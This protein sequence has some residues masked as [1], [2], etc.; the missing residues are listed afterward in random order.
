MGSNKFRAGEG[1]NRPRAGEGIARPRF[2]EDDVA[3]SATR[4]A[5]INF[6]K[7]S[8]NVPGPNR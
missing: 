8:Y 7:L 5:S 3:A 2:D 1:V 4:P 6:F